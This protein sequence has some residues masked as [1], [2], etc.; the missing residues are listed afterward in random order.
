MKNS[1]ILKWLNQLSSTRAAGM[2]MLLFAIAIGVATFIE[3]DFGTSAAQELIF[4]SHWFE[5]LLFLFGCSILA[6]LWRYRLYQQKKW[7]SLS[8][9]LAIIIILIGSAV[10]RYTGTEGMMHIR[11]G[12]TTNQYLSA[13]NYLQFRVIEGSKTYSFEEPTH[14][15]SL[16]SNKFNESYQIGNTILAINL[17]DF[18][19]NPSE[20]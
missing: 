18:I 9:H 8:F 7:A 4:K 19:P 15:S 17:V 2:Y 1:I 11:E 3:N 10:T 12:E 14:F 16:S 13:E 6:N 5:L 20:N